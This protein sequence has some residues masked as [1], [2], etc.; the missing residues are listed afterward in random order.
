M[1]KDLISTVVDALSSQGISDEVGV[2]VVAAMQGE[3]ELYECI[4]GAED[5]RPE[6]IAQLT[7]P[8]PEPA[9]AYL[10]AIEVEGFR[11]IGPTSRLELP[12]G[13]G[14]TVISGRNGC[15]KSSFA[16][17]LEVALTSNSYRW[18]NRNAAWRESWRNVHQTENTRITIE[19][20]VQDQPLTAVGVEWEKDTKLQDART[21]TQARGQRRQ[22]GLSGL[23]W[24]A[25]LEA[26]RPFLPHDELS[27]L[28]AEPSKLYKALSPILGLE[29]I[30]DAQSRLKQALGKVRAPKESANDKRAALA[31]LLRG[32]KDERAQQAFDLTHQRYPDLDAVA[33]LIIGTSAVDQRG[34]LATLASLQSLKCPAAEILQQAITNHHAA[35][36]ELNSAQADFE[37]AAARR[38][39]LLGLALEHH[40]QAGDTACPVCETGRLDADWA[41]RTRA[42]LV[43]DQVLSKRLGR[44]RTAAANH[45]QVL[46]GM[47]SPP[48]AT[49][50]QPIELGAE[51]AD[52]VQ[53]A[54]AA[55][56]DWAALTTVEQLAS[57]GAVVLNQL[58]TAL[59]ELHK[60]A[61]AEIEARQDEWQR[62]ALLLS[63]WHTDMTAAVA[64]EDQIRLVDAAHA[65]IKSQAQALRAERMR[66]L[67]ERT[68]SIWSQLRHESN[69]DIADVVLQPW[70][71]S[72]RVHF[73]ATVDG[74]KVSALGVLSQGEANALALSVFLPKATLTD[75]PFGFLMIDDPVQAMDPAKVDGLAKVLHE[76]AQDR[77][78]IVLTHDDR[79]AEAVRRLELPATM[80]QVARD[81]RSVVRVRENS[82][83]ARNLLADARS[84]AKDPDMDDKVR[85]L[86]LPT[87]VRASIESLCHTLYFN[88]RLR[89][90]TSRVEVDAGWAKAHTTR[91]MVD[92]ALSTGDVDTWKRA[93]PHRTRVMAICAA[94]HHKGL[95]GNPLTAVD[96]LRDTLADLRAHRG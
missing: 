49:L 25:A 85:R 48:P 19:L 7:E 3:K 5:A 40:D 64:A 35:Q 58:A 80:L 1:S 13:P 52:A 66:P 21:W 67:S 84:V 81:L 65:W 53:Q 6:P 32:A 55:W 33:E 31:P 90:G 42:E 60:V 79:L 26:H 16:E 77:Q 70:A 54:R 46:L 10:A 12:L 44:A 29:Q 47:A 96:D 39:Q 71:S 89:A 87:L 57:G 82:D 23:G 95:N 36:L 72:G 38:V 76:A 20:A 50:T 11:G 61:Q 83:E 59:G 62:L 9:R 63:D 41:E 4:E 69:V 24:G 91:G 45:K 68:Q 30:T 43:Q 86:V 93:K 18:K 8:A 14:L 15:G 56:S 28:V 94:G 74:E 2:L 88:R 51:L 27:S 78:V 17:A 34:P 73:P 92:L 75:S 22:P 37:D